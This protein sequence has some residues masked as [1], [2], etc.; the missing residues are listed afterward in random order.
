MR[1][2]TRRR[3][4]KTEIYAMLGVGLGLMGRV[5]RRKKIQAAKFGIDLHAALASAGFFFCSERQLWVGGDHSGQI[6]NLAPVPR[7][8]LLGS[9]DRL[10]VAVTKWLLFGQ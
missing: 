8:A 2:P 7:Y 9:Q 10:E 4:T 5:G 6:I 3:S 1:F